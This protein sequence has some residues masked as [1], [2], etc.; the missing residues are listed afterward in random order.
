MP[1]T[2]REF[3]VRDALD[4]VDNVQAQLSSERLQAYRAKRIPDENERL[5]FVLASY[6]PAPA[7]LKMLNG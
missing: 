3:G 6:T 2:A 4:P 7:M 1:A 5:K